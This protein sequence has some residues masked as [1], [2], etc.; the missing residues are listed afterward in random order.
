MPPP[1]RQPEAFR[2][3]LLAFYDQHGRDLP[4]RQVTTPYAI[5]LSEIMLQQTTVATVKPYF[6]R[7]LEAFP[8]VHD[9]A[10]ATE[11]EVLTL[12]QGLGYYSRA[13]NLHA[14]AKTV[15]AAWD[16]Q[17]PTTTEDLLK[18]PGIGPYTAAAIA[19]IAFNAQATV[20]DGNV[21]RVISR[22]YRLA[23][24]LPKAKTEIRP[25]ATALTDPARPGAYAG[26]IM[27]LGATV[28]TPRSPSCAE[29]PVQR[30]CAGYAAGDQA[31][32]PRKEPK[33]KRPEKTGVAWCIFDRHGRLYLRQRPAKGLLASL[34]EVPHTGWEEHAPPLP[35]IAQYHA[36][37]AVDAGQ[38]RHVFTHFGL[39]LDVRRLDLPTEQPDWVSPATLAR[40]PLPTLMRKVLHR[41][42]AEAD[43]Q[44]SK[45]RATGA[46]ERR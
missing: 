23:T 25:L 5:W 11:Q 22:L 30:W 15:V 38:I 21:E 27:D 36:A 14:C 18:L 8:T 19:A 26:A 33:A 28:C 2:Q 35:E 9:L 46:K 29:C 39:T 40:H 41:A 13:R 45:K 1:H 17:F 37:E 20:V 16:G 34:W 24:P 7:F 6:W 10:R 4:W 32:Y 42:L 43:P 44:P 3:H 12:W 31:T